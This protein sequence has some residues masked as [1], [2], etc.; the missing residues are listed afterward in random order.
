MFQRRLLLAALGAILVAPACQAAKVKVWDQHA[1]TSFDKAQFQQAVVSSEGAIRL[2]RRLRPFADL[3]V[4]HVW[5]LVEVKDGVLFAAAGDEGKV[6]KIAADGKASVVYA[7]DASRPFCLAAAGDDAVYVGAGP[8]GQILRVDAA[9][10]VKPVCLTGEPYVWSLAVDGKTGTLYAGTGPHGHVWKISPDGPAKVLYTAK[11]EHVLCV[12]AGAD[13]QVYVGVDKSGLVYRIDEKGKA[14]VLYQAAQA[15]VRCLRVTADAVYVGTSTPTKRHGGAV[16]ST[17]TGSAATASLASY[18]PEAAASIGDKPTKDEGAKAG[19]PEADSKETKET[20]GSPASA[21]SAPSGGENSVYRIGLDGGVREVFREKAMV[22]SLVRQ[23]GHVF[24]GT[25]MDGQLFEVDDATREHSEIARLDHGQVLCMCQRRDGSVLLGAGDPGKLYLLEDR[26]AVRGTMIS[27]VLDAKLVSK[28]GAL[29]WEADAPAKTAVSVAVRS[30]N[31]AE[32][33]DTWG[34]WS[35][36][37][38]DAEKAVID[39]PPA[40]FLQYR[41]TLASEDPSVTPS[42]RGLT[43]RYQTTNQAPEVTKVEA[44]DLNAVNLDSPKKLK[45]KW[46]AVDANED[47]LTFGLYV[48]K[49]GWKGWMEVEEDFDK[50]EYEWDSTTTPDG[51]YQLKV[52]AS[53]RRDNA[54]AEALTGERVSS[55]FVVCHTPPAVKVKAT[56]AGAE[57]SIEAS[58]SSPLVRLTAASYTLNGKKWVNVFPADGLFDGPAKAF[59]FKTEGLK[60]GTYVLVLRVRD[61]AG[62]TGSGDVVF[63]VE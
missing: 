37:Q 50:T 24:V 34:D 27:E 19:A 16:A 51:V 61:A 3:D 10:K 44:P 20:K 35:A 23:N 7:D 15:E 48:R 56:V 60:P 42:V 29:R 54:D 63:T 62:N 22:L 13:G 14:F 49:D 25:G 39:A 11:Q 32:P 17:P 28:W 9:G 58:S 5:D 52:T 41:L 53:D 8:N 31:T 12:A 36:E 55:P 57:A 38:T 6:Y 30:G 40:R 1:P 47:E 46:S 33:D 59:K 26:Y 2:G 18:R 45:F 43:L 4:S 21:P